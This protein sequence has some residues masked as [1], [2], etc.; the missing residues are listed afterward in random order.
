VWK[1]TT[2]YNNA[3]SVDAGPDQVAW[4][5]KSGTTGQEVIALAGTYSDDGKPNPPGTCT[6][7]WTQVSGPA[8][9]AIVPDNDKTAAVTITTA[10]V[11][12]FM[13]TVDDGEKQG[14]DTVRVIVGSDSCHASYLNGTNYNSKDFNLDCTV[15][16]IDF[17]DFAADWLACT[18]TFEGC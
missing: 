6:L 1:F 8:D 3:P 14:S 5:G 11:Y 10:G 17:A 15:N 13:L 9:A 4:L 2:D 16:L 18:N 7:R 12:Q